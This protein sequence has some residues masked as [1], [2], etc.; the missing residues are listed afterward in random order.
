MSPQPKL[1]SSILC[2]SFAFSNFRSSGLLLHSF[3]CNNAK[4]YFNT[5]AVM[6]SPSIETLLNYIPTEYLIVGIFPRL[7]GKT[8]Q[9]VVFLRAVDDTNYLCVDR[10]CKNELE[11]RRL[12]TQ[13]NCSAPEYF[14]NEGNAFRKGP[15]YFPPEFSEYS[16]TG[17]PTGTFF[18]DGGYRL[19]NVTIKVDEEETSPRQLTKPE[20]TAIVAVPIVIVLVLVMVLIRRLTVRRRKKMV[21]ATPSKLEPEES[22]HS[23]AGSRAT[24]KK[25]KGEEK[26]GLSKA[27]RALNKIFRA[28]A[29]PDGNKATRTRSR[30][31]GRRTSKTRSRFNGRRTTKTR[32]SSV[33]NSHRTTGTRTRSRFNDGRTI[34][35]TTSSGPDD[36]RTALTVTSSQHDSPK[37]KKVPTSV[38][39]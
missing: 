7:D 16:K 36:R 9:S 25:T 32:L 10:E 2:P 20:I 17:V 33:F 15:N 34:M 23:S 6:Q 37:R 13:P 21:D 22:R 1:V 18:L 8:I 19:R 5:N 39:I 29:R 28:K 14:H 4:C 27:L 26:S 35:T 12:W 3:G 24:R 11:Y 31:E 38:T 30:H